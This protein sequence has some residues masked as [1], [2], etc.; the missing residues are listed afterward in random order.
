MKKIRKWRLLKD[1]V[2]FGK[3]SFAILSPDFPDIWILVSWEWLTIGARFFGKK[4]SHLDAV[5]IGIINFGNREA[6][7]LA[8]LR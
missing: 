8:D 3:N 2:N 6:L 7:V 5:S 1:Q 4:W